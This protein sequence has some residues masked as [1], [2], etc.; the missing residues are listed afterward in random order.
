MNAEDY[1]K[2]FIGNLLA[3][4]KQQNQYKDKFHK[5]IEDKIVK[6]NETVSKSIKQIKSQRYW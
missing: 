2:D 5:S 1:K 3:L 6:F 4:Q